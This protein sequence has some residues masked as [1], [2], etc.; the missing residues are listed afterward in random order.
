M[1]ID[2]HAHLNFRDYKDLNDVIK[3]ALDTNVKKIICVSSNI[4]D[5]I[6][7][8]EIARKYPGIVFAAVGIHPQCTDPEN[9]EEIKTQ[10]SKLEEL[11]LEN[12]EVVIAIGECGLDFSDVGEGERNRN[13]DEQEK[14][15]IGQIE[16][17]KKYDL[18]ILLHFN[19]AHDYF[20]DN[21]SGLSDMKGIFHCYVGGK[22]R[23]KKFF[24]Y[25]DFLFG[26]TGLITYDEGLQQ[27]VKKIPLER[28]VLE[29]DCPFLA[30][31]PYRGER[32]E[33]GYIPLTA[34]KVAEIRNT[35]IDEV[36]R[37]TTENAIKLFEIN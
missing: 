9:S 8:I 37:V 21:Y 17:A 20:L 10:I 19:K 14:L 33:P 27:V 31:L 6:I 11:I 22:K 2:T 18:P 29:T 15:F 23:L 28:I 3:R 16:L 13:I 4:E 32:N 24:D 35:S 26:I 1:F 34:S 12:R 5:S 7:S 30:P 36:E 25:K